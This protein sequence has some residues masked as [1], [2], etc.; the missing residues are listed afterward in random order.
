[1]SMMGK[2]SFFLGL[3]ISQSPRG[4][5]INQYKYASE[6]VMWYAMSD[7]VDTPLVEK[8]KLDKDLHRKPVDATL[9]NGM[10]G[11]LMYLTF[12]RPDLTYAVCLCAWY[13]AKPTEKHLNTVKR[14]SKKQKFT[15]ILSTEAEYIALSG[16]C[17][18]ILWMRSQLT[19]YGFQF[20]EIPLYCDNKSTIALCCNFVQHSKAKHIDVRYHFIREKVKNEIVELYFLS[21]D[22]GSNKCSQAEVKPAGTTDVTSDHSM[23]PTGFKIHRRAL[24]KGKNHIVGSCWLLIMDTTQAQ[25]KDLDDALEPTLQVVLDALNLTPFYKAFEIT[26]DIPKIYM[27]ELWATNSIHH[28]SLHFK[29][30][31]KSHTVNVENFRNMLQIF[32]KPPGKKFEDPLFE[33]EILSFIRDL[34]HNGEIKFLFYVNLN[35]MHQPWTSFVAIINKCLSGKTTGHDSL[36]LSRA[37][38]LWGLYHNKNVDYVFLLWEDLVYQ[39]IQIYGAILPKQLTNQAMIESEAYKTYYAYATAKVPKS[40]K[41][42][43]PA[44]GLETLSEIALSEAEQMKIT[45]KR[46]MTQFHVSHASDS[47]A[48]EGTSFKP[49]VLDAPKYGS[50]DEKIS[51]KSSD[52]DDDNEDTADDNADDE[53]DDEKRNEKLDEEE[54]G[55]DLRVQTPSH[56]ESTDDVTQGDNVE[57]EK[58]DEVKINKEK[59][60]NELYN[61]VNINLKGRDTE[62]TDALLSNVKATQVTKDTHVIMT[63]VTLEV[64]QQSSSVSSSFISNMLN[65]NPDAVFTPIITPSTSL[66]NLPTFGSLF[67]FENR[68]KALED[69][70]SE[71]KQTNLFA[72]AISLILGIIDTYLANKMNEAVKTAVQLQSDRLRD[73]AQAKNEKF[74]NK[75]DENIK[76]IIKEQVKVQ[77]KEQVSKILPRIEKLV[78]EQLKAEVLTRSSNE[79]KT[80]HAVAANLSELELKKI[81]IDKIES[82]KSIHRSNQHKTLYKELINAYETDKVI[83]DTYGDTV[84]FKRRRDGEDDDEEPFAGSNWKSKRRRVRKEPESSNEL[85]HTAEE[86]EELVHQEL[87]TGFTEDHP[88]EEASQLLDW[89]KKPAKPL[90]PDRDWNKT[91][92]AA[93]GPIQPWINNLAQKEDTHDSFNEL[94]DTPL[95]FSAFMMNRLKDDTLTSDILAGPTFELTKGSCKSLVEL[96]YFLEEVHKATTDELD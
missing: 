69:D 5:F 73:E 4:I 92:P 82:N 95:D 28:A 88:V 59:E 46:S 1:M 12:S 66:Q 94:M 6:I 30:N 41:K 35:H 86:L 87:N 63:V 47:G 79:S 93:H 52:E 77:V 31:D 61:D 83:L 10:I 89:F 14:S 68:V 33:K 70:F 16:C 26:A 32:P 58:L 38:I 50:N 43:L 75:L 51:W 18:Q 7:S 57:E 62:M 71:F 91:L 17:A 81:L 48:H 2:M 53:D 90:T 49:G 54:E 85:I 20:N 23:E 34:G 25:Q 9:Y 13:Q 8:T 29:M 44:H 42:K 40:G 45:T 78:N 65:P 27:Q 24:L 3:Q 76:N 84:T 37:Q 39:T 96:E 15:A 36:C 72:E 22:L 80:S 67:K 74:I 56:F 11:S 60:V 55:S 19:D 64:Q 21:P